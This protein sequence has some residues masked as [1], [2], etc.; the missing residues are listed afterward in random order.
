[1]EIDASTFGEPLTKE[2]FKNWLQHCQLKFD[3]Q[4]IW[5]RLSG[6]YGDEILKAHLKKTTKENLEKHVPQ[7]VADF[8]WQW[9][10][11]GTF[12]LAFFI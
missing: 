8:L 4:T 2:N 12:I 7:L 10:G 11:L 5:G 3:A 9:A 1:M 6:E